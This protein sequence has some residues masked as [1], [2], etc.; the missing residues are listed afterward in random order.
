MMVIKLMIKEMHFKNVDVSQLAHTLYKKIL[1]MF[2]L[3]IDLLHF[4]NDITRQ[5]IHLVA[6]VS[7]STTM[8]LA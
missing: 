8:W 6:F 7:M 3:L 4:F 1:D 5:I 2:T